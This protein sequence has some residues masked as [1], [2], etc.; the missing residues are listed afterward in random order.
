MRGHEELAAGVHQLTVQPGV[1]CWALVDESGVTLVDTGLD[2]PGLIERL[3]HL[4]IAPTDVGRILLTHGHPDHAGGIARLRRAGSA[5]PVHVGAGDLATVRGEAPQPSTDGST[6]L[7]RLM[8]RLPRPGPFGRRIEVLDAA[9]LADGDVLPGAGGVRA[10]ATPGHTPGHLAYHLPARDVLLGGDVV[11]N[12]F[13]LR[14][15]PPFLCWRAPVNR[16][17]VLRLAEESPGTLALAHGRP[18]VGD[19]AGRLRQLVTDRRG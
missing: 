12:L 15:A 17:S 3:A 8:D 6:R 16:R 18:V 10:I 4:G 2:R 5:A 13:R 7:G 11:F 14:P 9:S 1:N 19:V